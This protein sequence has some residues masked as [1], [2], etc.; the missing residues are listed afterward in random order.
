MRKSRLFIFISILTIIFLFGTAALID[1]CTIFSVPEVDKE[2]IKEAEEET[3]KDTD[4]LD[5]TDETDEE[6]KEKEGPKDEEP[7]QES[8][9]P[10]IDLVIYEG[11]TYSED[12]DD[13]LL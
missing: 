2:D 5:T 8:Q 10:T 9:A 3:I 4:D 11:P 6:T 7:Q 12:D 1:R 13:V